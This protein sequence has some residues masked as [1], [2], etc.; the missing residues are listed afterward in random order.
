MKLLHFVL[1]SA[2]AVALA[3][4]SSDDGPIIAPNVPL[5]STRFINAMPDTGATTWRFIDQL[6]NSPVAVGLAFRGFSPY[7]ATAVG[8]RPLKVFAVYP[9]IDDAQR[10]FIDSV[11]T[12]EE[13][14]RYTLMQVGMARTG[15]TPAERMLVIE[16]V[17][18][19]VPADQFAI[20]FV[21][22]GAGLGPID[23]YSA[24]HLISPNS[25]ATPLV[26][27]LPYLGVSPYVLIAA[28]PTTGLASLGATATAYTRTTG[29]FLEDG[30]AVG[31]QIMGN[32]FLR[33]PNNTRS[34]V[35]AVTATSLSIG[36][37]TGAITLASTDEGFTRTTGS[38]VDEGFT[39]GM[40]ILVSGFRPVTAE[41]EEDDIQANNRVF[42]I[43]DV[44]ATEI[45]VELD[46]DEV[47]LVEAAAAGRTIS[48]VLEAEA[49]APGRLIDAQLV[50]RAFQAGT[51]TRLA[52]LTAPTGLPEEP[53]N[54]LEP[55][56]GTVMPGSIL[57]A[58]FMPRSVSG[59]DATSFTTPNFVYIVDKHPR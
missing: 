14:K 56:G 37:T 53:T 42:V 50:F 22:A 43:D 59:S 46:E 57:T 58:V 13:D 48:K 15:S 35:T 11:F 40:R 28:S 21:H 19:T 54:L 45:T 36:P 20:R 16:D 5:A 30:F 32:R 18:P 34:I 29:S 33:G 1:L 44:D 3:G 9:D 7:Q 6:E 25:P 47:L 26:T 8:E 17:F 27:N 52:Q 4:C 49:E 51:T 23:I 38:F 24:N 41:E 2:G 39:S 31:M 55:V 10:T 12:F